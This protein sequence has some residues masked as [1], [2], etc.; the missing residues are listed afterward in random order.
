M[1]PILFN[2]EMVKAM[3]DGRK[4]VTR[5]PAKFNWGEDTE[6]V[7]DRY[8]THHS[9]KYT[10]LFHQPNGS[11]SF[12]SYSNY[13]V[14]DILYVRE[15]WQSVPSVEDDGIAYVYKASD[16]GMDWQNNTE[17]WKWRPSIHMP[18]EAARIFLKVTD[19][20]VE[21]VQSISQQELIKE[22]FNHNDYLQGDGAYIHYSEL[23]NA[24]YGNWTENPWVWVYEF[25]VVPEAQNE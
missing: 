13:E 2:T 8:F 15:T 14:G 16:N 6:K 7:L 19:V 1:K 5:R 11:F 20:R 17:D 25:E 24:L 12:H 3:L 10:A 21:R 23:W 4:T 22:G 9:G 18:K